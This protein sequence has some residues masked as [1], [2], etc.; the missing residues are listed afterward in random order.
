MLKQSDKLDQPYFLGFPKNRYIALEEVE[1]FLKANNVNLKSLFEVLCKVHDG[2]LIFSFGD[3]TIEFSRGF[4]PWCEQ[5]NAI[6][7]S[8]EWQK[9]NL[10][11][12]ETH[13]YEYR[14][15]EFEALRKNIQLKT[16]G[17]E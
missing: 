8:I 10:G 6:E 1:A 5:E 17:S 11:N 2:Y 4:K 15:E 9:D 12:A 13:D 14:T 7:L 3:T 16:A